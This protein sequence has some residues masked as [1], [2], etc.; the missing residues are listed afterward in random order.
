MTIKFFYYKKK[1]TKRQFFFLLNQQMICTQGLRGALSPAKKV[2][3]I[4]L[5]LHLY[6]VECAREPSPLHSVPSL[7]SM[8]VVAVL[9]ARQPASGGSLP[10]KLSGCAVSEYCESVSQ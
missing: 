10:K 1:I 7:P 3:V 5:T 4:S 9:R 8:L 2:R 6:F